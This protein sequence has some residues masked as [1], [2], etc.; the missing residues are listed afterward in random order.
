MLFLGIDQQARQT[1]R[2]Q[3]LTTNRALSC[4]RCEDLVVTEC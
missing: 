4:Q 2:Q 3:R 1:A